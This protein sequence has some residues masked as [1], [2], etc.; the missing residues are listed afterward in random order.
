MKLLY[1]RTESVG[2]YDE[3]LTRE[4]GWSKNDAFETIQTIRFTIQTMAYL[5]ETALQVADN[6]PNQIGQFSLT[7]HPTQ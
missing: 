7:N 3:K 2:G 6:R 5:I 4:V 1:A